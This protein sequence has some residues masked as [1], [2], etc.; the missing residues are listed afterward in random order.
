MLNKNEFV[1]YVL[2]ERTRGGA[3]GDRVA[4]LAGDVDD[5]DD[6]VPSAALT[7]DPTDFARGLLERCFGDAPEMPVADI[8]VPRDEADQRRLDAE[9]APGAHYWRKTAERPFHVVLVRLKRTGSAVLSGAARRT[10]RELQL[11]EDELHRRLQ[12]GLVWFERG[13][14]RRTTEMPQGAQTETLY[15]VAITDDRPEGQPRQLV[16]F[17]TR[18]TA[19]GALEAFVLREEVLDW[20][21]ALAREHLDAFFARHLDPLGEGA[22][23]QDAFVTGEERKKAR[24]LMD[25]CSKL[26]PD[27][28]QLQSAI[29]DLLDEIAG[30]FGLRRKGGK[31]GHRL[32]LHALPENHSIA[33][34]PPEARKKGFQNPF[35]GIRVFDA[36]ERL[37]GYIVYVVNGKKSAASLAQHLRDHNHFHNVLVVYPDQQDTKVELWQGG[38][39]LTGSLRG[40]RRASQF[41]GD[42][43]VIQLLSRFFIVSRT[44]ISR[45]EDL[46]EELAWRAQH[47]RVLALAELEKELNSESGPLYSLF[48]AFNSLLAPTTPDEFA[49]AYAQAITY[50][51][52]SAR[53]LTK[54]AGTRF[55]R[56]K[57]ASRLPM[58]SPFLRELFQHLLNVPFDVNLSWLLDDITSVL[59]RT[60][61][62]SVFSGDT[63]PSIHFYEAFLGIYDPSTRKERGVY[64]TPDEIVRFMVR[65]ADNVVS[66][67]PDAPDLRSSE[68]RLLDP[69]TGTGTFLREAVTYLAASGDASEIVDRVRGMELMLAP[70]AICH[71]RLSLLRRSLSPA[72]N[73]T[74]IRVMFANTLEVPHDIDSGLFAG[75]QSLAEEADSTRDV[76]LE[77]RWTLV[78]GNPPYKNN[79]ALTLAQI[80]DRFPSLLDT[81][82][83]ASG[84]QKRNIRD[85]YAWFFAAADSLTE[86]GGCICLITPDSYLRKSSYRHFRERL[87]QRYRIGSVVRLGT[88]IFANVGPRI[89]FSIIVMIR[90]AAEIPDA[91]EHGP[92][93]FLDISGLAA[94]EHSS[95]LGTPNDPRL[96]WLGSLTSTSHTPPT[97]CTT[98]QV[99]PSES[100]D[101][102]FL[103]ATPTG[104]ERTLPVQIV[105]RSGSGMASIFVRKWPGII[106]AFDVLLRAPTWSELDTKMRRFFDVSRGKGTVALEAFGDELQCN[107]K[108]RERLA[109]LCADSASRGLTYDNAC[110]KPVFG[111]TLP[112]GMHWYPPLSHASWIYYEPAIRIPRNVNPGKDSGWGWM[113]QWR[114][115]ES[116]EVFPKLIF[117]TST[118]RNN[119]F[120]AFVV[121]SDWY[122]KLHGAASQQFHYVTMRDPTRDSLLPQQNNNLSDE[123]HRLLNRFQSWGLEAADILYFIAALYNSRLGSD[124][125]EREEE[126]M[127][128]LPLVADGDRATVC[129]IVALARELHAAREAL[130]AATFEGDAR[131]PKMASGGAS[132]PTLSQMIENNQALLD[133]VVVEWLGLDEREEE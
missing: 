1:K 98:G 46:A 119:G 42:G 68:V 94:G 117:T 7:P 43:G 99:A 27:Q 96:K 100:N 61:V 39:P 15:V 118:N 121:H 80:A 25:E 23:W 128:P 115:P 8:L 132:A 78:I 109:Y 24:K 75:I 87:L 122:A 77:R 101:F 120:R 88:E 114:D 111:G 104:G 82:R 51:L 30:S 29:R 49:D 103:L 123:G 62:E 90:R 6:P 108:E 83:D 32:V 92:F 89:N 116:H 127:L 112:N 69:A 13:G 40:E 54:G 93:S 3:A 85:D 105:A 67:D 81:S 33:V 36:G 58:S 22:K 73:E 64:Y 38:Q 66:S 60:K 71:L 50:G 28:K 129:R 57:A 31:D 45:P 20:D 63:D 35:Q 14:P 125:I 18:A 48:S 26:L 130:E 34:D 107:E 131:F 44:D 102:R 124:Y 91:A 5:F 11:L 59:A 72:A 126:S 86:G 17:G 56:A 16:C 65:L 84:A 97:A 52:L 19:T 12:D 53:W 9:Y 37:L 79:S 55:T 74:P 113:Q 47:L 95:V 41:N 70:Y 76:K 2:G 10:V 106:T 21:A 133:G 110:I 4:A